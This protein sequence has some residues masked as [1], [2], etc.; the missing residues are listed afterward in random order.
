MRSLLSG[1]PGRKGDGVGE[2]KIG[3]S[4]SPWC[5]EQLELFNIRMF[6]KGNS[7]KL[8]RI[9]ESAFGLFLD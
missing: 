4:G 5:I 6:D 2:I 8:S 1:L 9:F 3:G 7:L